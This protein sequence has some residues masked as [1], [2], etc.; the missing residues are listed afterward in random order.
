[1]FSSFFST[2]KNKSTSLSSSKSFLAT[3]PNKKTLFIFPINGSLNTYPKNEQ[4][5]P[6]NSYCLINFLTNFL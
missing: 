3:E 6:T 5:M 2:S 1:M 4:L